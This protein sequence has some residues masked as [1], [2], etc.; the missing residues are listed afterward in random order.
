MIITN[1]IIPLILTVVIELLITFLMGFRSRLFIFT[2][3]IVNL[4]TNPLL[5]YV[6]ILIGPIKNWGL[7]FSMILSL[8]AIIVYGEWR[9]LSYCFRELKGLFTLSLSMN[10]ASF[11][12]GGIVFIK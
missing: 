8:E 9:M 7:N 6:L 4:V 1:F 12:L 11:V 3:I 2:V 10:L 5:N